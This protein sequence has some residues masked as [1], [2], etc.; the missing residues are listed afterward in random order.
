VVPFTH[1]LSE[2]Q[3]RLLSTRPRG[4]TA[5]LDGVTLAIQN[6]KKA[7]NRRRAIIVLAG[8]SD[9]NGPLHIQR[10]SEPCA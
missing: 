6:M 9:N 7:S 4:S 3:N 2:I 5:L 10:S 8:G 1:D